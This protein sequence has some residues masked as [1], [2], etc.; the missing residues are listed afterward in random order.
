M[1]YKKL[2]SLGIKKSRENRNITQEQLAEKI[3]VSIETIKNIE[4]CKSTP[5]A[6]TIDKICEAFNT[7]PYDLLIPPVTDSQSEII[8]DIDKKLK[9][10]TKE[11]LKF[12]DE[13]I[14]L[15]RRNV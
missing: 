15:Y 10:C 6:K 2:L 5:T 3:D 12:I 11:Q 4:Q 9:L 7:T 13:F 14:D 8:A 1:D